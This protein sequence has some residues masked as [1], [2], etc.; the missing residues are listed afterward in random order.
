MA[1]TT[2]AERVVVV[3]ADGTPITAGASANVAKATAAPPVYGEGAFV[4]LSVDLGGV[5]RST[6]GGGGGGLTDA[7]L[8]ATPVPVSGDVNVTDRAVRLV[9]VVYG[10]QGQQ[11]KQTATNFNMATELHV[12]ATAIDPRS[13]RT[14]TSADNVTV[15]NASLAVTIAAAVDVSDRAGRLVGITY[16]DVGQVLQRPVSRDLLVQLRTATTEYDA[17]QIR[18]LTSA[19]V[20]DVS[21]RVGRALGVVA[22]ITAAVDVSDRAARLVGVVYGSQAQQLKQTATNFNA[23]VEVAVGATLIDPR[24]IRALTSADV[25]TANAGT[26]TFNTQ[27][28]AD[29]VDNAVFTDTASKVLPVGFIFDEVAGT[30]LTENDVAAARLDSKRALISVIE[31]SVTRGTRAA[32]DAT[33]KALHVTGR[34]MEALG[35]YKVK[36]RTATYAA[37][38]AAAPLFSMR[39]GVLTVIIRVRIF[40]VTTAAATTAGLTERELIIAR[41]FTAS[42]TGGTAVVLTGNNQKMRTSHATSGV[43]DMRFGAPLTAGTRTLDA[44]AIA[45]AAGWS[46]LLSTGVVIGNGGSSGVAAARSTEGGTGPVTLYDINRDDYPIVLTANEG[47]VVR[48]GPDAQPAGATQQTYVMV[49]WAE[50]SAY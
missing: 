16:G 30:A 3:N 6:A 24:S 9:G 29:L 10:S 28:A 45:S 22:S 37:L 1:D 5:L 11:L 12:G 50:V 23:Q 34:P 15:A 26:G 18:A 48:I 27:D 2:W 20:V 39:C 47:I 14:L 42:D 19:D 41:G 25:V 17:R 46:G 4:P 32:V 8:R 38:A 44:N 33:L 21:D 31:D 49:D 7:Q 43:T 36:G 40:V 13:I 35:F